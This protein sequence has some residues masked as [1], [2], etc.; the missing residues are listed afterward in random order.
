MRDYEQTLRKLALNDDEVVAS[1]LA[2]S[3]TEG[4]SGSDP[5]TLALVRL[6][7]LIAIAGSPGSYL[8]A[9]DA[10]LAAGAP[11]EDVVGV[12]IAV[13]PTVGSARLV[14]AAPLVAGAVGYDVDAAFDRD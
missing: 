9:V 14:A 6:A 13:A 3:Q 1:V 11:V 7:A 12:L 4:A 8:S 5:Q 2:Q 10:A